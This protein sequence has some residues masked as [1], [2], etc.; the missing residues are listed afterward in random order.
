MIEDLITKPENALLL[1][2]IAGL[3]EVCKRFLKKDNWYPVLALAFGVVLVYIGQY[4]WADQAYRG[5][6]LGLTASGF[7][8]SWKKGKTS[9]CKSN[10][11]TK[12][13][14]TKNEKPD[15]GHHALGTTVPD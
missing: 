2:I 8:W 1:V 13:G 12:T 9:V 11:K 3:V 14:E 7:V 15:T 6:I 10:G 4:S 5:L